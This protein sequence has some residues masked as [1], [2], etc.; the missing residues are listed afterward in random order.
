M[1]APEP[2]TGGAGDR[3]TPGAMEPG[4]PAVTDRQDR[5]SEPA[6]MPRQGVARHVHEPGAVPGAV[7]ESPA[8]ESPAV[9]VPGET[10]PGETV[11]GGTLVGY[12]GAAGEGAAGSGHP[13]RVAVVPASAAGRRASGFALLLLGI[14]GGLAPFVGPLFGF[15]PA[16]PGAWHWSALRGLLSVAPGALAA[17]MGLALLSAGVRA[18]ASGTLAGLLALVA[19][20]W[21]T[22]GTLAWPT[23]HAQIGATSLAPAL[24]PLGRFVNDV[25]AFEGVG[26][27]VVVLAGMA[28]AASLRRHRVAREAV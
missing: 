7:V 2:M 17:L 14:W 13:A 10:V 5:I 24:A 25:G 18:R 1:S 21:F 27:V 6:A 3:W 20:A 8:A 4:D 19:G 12:P 23:F 28:M 9:P 16:G 15:M 22:L 26:V 11:P